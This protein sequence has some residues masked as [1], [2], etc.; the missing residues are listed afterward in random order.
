[1]KTRT[2]VKVGAA[3]IAALL[4][5]TLSTS[6][7]YAKGGPKTGSIEGEVIGPNGPIGGASVY[8]FGEGSFDWVA[9]TF[10]DADGCFEFRRILAGDYT[11]TALSLEP[12]C[13]GNAP[14]TV[15]PRETASVVINMD[16]LP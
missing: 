14:V 15:V 11:V 9:E 7:I 2:R 5:L 1:M 3:V 12:P 16:C 10:T 6:T 4:V 13:H 8:L